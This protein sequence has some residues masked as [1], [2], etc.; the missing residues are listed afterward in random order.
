MKKSGL[1]LISMIFIQC[2]FAGDWIKVK[3][4]EPAPAKTTLVSSTIETSVV[5]FSIPGFYLDE[6]T[7]PNGKEN[8]I[9]LDEA[10]PLLQAGDP[11]LAKLTVSVMIPDLARMNFEVLSSEY[12]EFENV[13]IAP[14]KGNFT[15]DIDPST[16]PYIYGKPYKQDQFYPGKLAELRDP[17][18]IRDYRGQTVIVYPFQYNPVSK[19]LRVYSDMEIKI[20]KTGN[21]GI[22]PLIK[23]SKPD[24]VNA[25]FNEIYKR[26]FLNYGSAKYTPVDEDGCMLII[27]YNS[28]MASM[29]DFV[30]WKKTIGIPVEMVD[31]AAIGNAAAIKTYIANYYGTHNLAFV[32]LV[33]DAAQVPSSY[34]NGDSDNNY[35]Y[36]VGTDHYPDIFIGRFSAETVAHVQ[37]QVQRTIDYEQSPY[38]GVDWYTKSIG[39][40]SDQGPGDDNELDYQH[41]R[42][43]DLDLLAYTYTYDYE[44]FDGSQGGHDAAGNPTPAQI[45][46]NIN[47]GSS[48]ILYTG[49]G[50]DISWG[51]SG[52]S[53]TNVAA[54]TNTQ[55]LPFIWSVACVN[56]NFVSTTCFAEAWLRSTS[57]GQPIGAVATLMST[58]NQ[59]W[60]PPMEGQDEMVD[61]LVE[62]YPT[63]IKRT[64]GALSMNG[65]MK[66]NDTYGTGG[67]AM[68]DTWT[69]FGDP[70]VIV[71]TAMPQ[72]LTVSHDPAI[73]LGA[74]QFTVFANKEGAKVCL[75]IN[76]EILGTGYISGGSATITFPAITGV[77]T[78][79]VAVT[80]YNYIPYIG[81]VTITPA[82]GPYLSY[83][84]HA[85]N[86]AAGNNNGLIDYGESILL[87]VAVKNIGTATANNVGAVLSSTDPYIS[88]TDNSAYYGNII[89]NQTV[90]VPNGFAFTVANNIPDGHTIMFSL[91]LSE[92]KSSWTA[93]FND[94]GHAPVLG[95]GGY[96]ISDPAGNNNG[97]LDPGE[98]A[99]LII[100][101]ENTG[102]SSAYNVQGTLVCTDSYITV[103]DAVN[104]Y[105][106]LTGGGSGQQSYSVT[107]DA[108]T[109]AGHIADFDFNLAANSGITGTG[110]FSIV[111]GQ[112]PVV[113]IDLDGNNNSS[114]AMT[115]A[116]NALGVPYDIFTTIPA[117]MSLYT[118]TFVCLGIYSL[119][120]VLTTAE[121][122]ILAD[123]LNNG[124]RL[125]MEG[126]D[127]WAYDAT[128][129]VHSMFG[130][131]GDS[132]GSADMATVLGQSGT[133]T[134]GM[135]FTY[136]GDNS[137]MD[138]LS[139]VAPAVAIFANQSPAYTCAVAYNPGTY[140][141]IGSSFEF[142]GLADG[143]APSTKTQLMNYYLS[144]FGIGS[145]LPDPPDIALDPVSFNVTV[146][147]DGS[148]VYNL[149]ITNNG[150]LDLSYTASTQVDAKGGGSK[151]YCTA[152]GTCDE[153]ISGVVFNTINNTSSCSQ[154]A[155]YT[156]ISTTVNAG[157]TYNIT[158]TNG[159]VYSTDDLGVWIDFNQDQDFTDAGENVVCVYS[160][161]GQG[162]YPILIPQDALP[163]STRMRIRIKYSGNDCGSSCGAT[164]YGEVEDYTVNIVGVNS[165]LS[166]DPGS[167]NVSGGNSAN[168]SVTF[169]AAGMTEGIYTGHI[170][171]NSNDP[172]ESSVVIPCT[173]NVASGFDLN[174][175]A[176]LDGPFGTTE[177]STILNTSGLLPLAQPFNTAPWNYAGTES[178]VSIPA[179]VVDWVLIELRDATSAA[180]A[181]PATRIARQAAFILKNGAVVG[182][183]GT[184]KLQF[185]NTVS[186]Q[187]F[188]IVW[189]RNHLGI[190]SAVGLTET[191]GTYNFD[192]TTA[193]GQAYG[194]NPQ[195]QLAAGVWGLFGGDADANGVI[196]MSD[197]TTEWKFEA[198]EAGLYSC[199]LNL[200]GQ[201][202]NV[203]KDNEWQPNI[204]KSCQ[205]P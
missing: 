73:F 57:G 195:K 34:S 110:S 76:N 184:S 186:N 199:D 150:D 101:A 45:S 185:T 179:N 62:S 118:A 122:Q 142:G 183:N 52:F 125:Y 82:S 107:A 177:M 22:N 53:N 128:T 154:Y 65:C 116:L 77:G 203:D 74:T 48:I 71:R 143:T 135:S 35:T 72:T 171:I 78:M 100:T 153:Y 63:N 97:L 26:Q 17:Y 10:S 112:I 21:D 16:V 120:H 140:R 37:T 119:N 162:T 139:A 105:G 151:A 109:P 91:Q 89:A 38:T 159:V 42:N 163:G 86:D 41:V 174:L 94:I 20:S 33:G 39:I 47:S 115:A 85:V 123:Y 108:G 13:I 36:I 141:T 126:G 156:S 134:S 30:N 144:F 55:K 168:H 121:G 176:M 104:S 99:D 40:A 69:V 160:N 11:D 60:N 106:T 166:I 130:L 46:V 5:H 124:G 137:Y 182:I 8:V 49:H 192:F 14:S 58:I 148:A 187:L 129:P 7:T 102:S 196:G 138:H 157:Q 9:L 169:D 147:P 31:V 205:V 80:H 81:T 90:S 83:F 2:L 165:W 12:T 24:K 96:V 175:K 25:Q 131:T 103:N 66:M 149:E 201:V 50:S 3:T 15:R 204:G 95:F 113:I 181:T 136:S 132:D 167:G 27:C 88:I 200:D 4:N 64:F 190:M 93:N 172:D 146:A 6:V 44:H 161:G 170:T 79:K 114:P 28:F 127:T 18:I 180:G 145:A 1:L 158:V 111:V 189:H 117:D 84:S 61:I 68:T 197:L 32:L 193:S 164:T 51:T 194:T 152:S 67:D 92:A 23:T 191:A 29:T 75:T 133:F 202:N 70:S 178:V 173:M 198:G 56:G 98:T 59:S 19:V 87:T 43:M 188:A 155:D 54:L